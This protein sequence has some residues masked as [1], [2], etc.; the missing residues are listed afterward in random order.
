LRDL[1][2]IKPFILEW[3][4]EAVWQ[5]EETFF[6]AGKRAWPSDLCLAVCLSIYGSTALSLDLA[7]FQFPE[8]LHSRLDSLDGG[9][10]RRKAAILHKGQQKQN[11]RTQTSMPQVGFDPS[12]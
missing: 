11:K 3:A 1:L 6:L 9:S 5:R 12:V 4:P 7:A 10:V 8:P 2:Q